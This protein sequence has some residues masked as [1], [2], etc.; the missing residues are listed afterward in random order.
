MMRLVLATLI[1]GLML[2]VSSANADSSSHCKLAGTWH[3]SNHF[4]GDHVM[5]MVRSGPNS[6]STLVASAL[7]HPWVPLALSHSRSHSV[8]RASRPAYSS[9]AD[10]AMR[11]VLS[12]IQA[13]A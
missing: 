5:T 6:Y 9:L 8:G 3:G 4:D 11:V 12:F 13:E 2:G 1:L 10:P 7:L